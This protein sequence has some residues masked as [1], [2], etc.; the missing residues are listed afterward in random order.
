MRIA[1]LDLG[2]NTFLCLIADVDAGEIKRVISD[3]ARV[4]RLG[5]DV[6]QS[7]RFHPEALARAEA[8]LADY[9]SEIRKQSVDRIVAAATSAARDVA[10]GEELLAI[11]RKHGIPIEIIS[12]VREAEST[13]LGTVS[14]RPS[15]PAAIIDVGGGSTEFIFGDA[16][17]I[18]EKISVDVG[19]VR[20][21]ELFVTGHPIA[22]RELDAMAGHIREKLQPVA[23][24]LRGLGL[25][26]GI[27]VAGTPTTLAAI[28]MGKPFDAELVHGYRFRIE[29]LHAW[30]NRLAAMT[31]AERQALNGL[32]AKRADVIPAGSLVLALGCEAL[33]LSEIEVSIRGLRYGLALLAEREETSCE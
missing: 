26:Q 27:A 9:A 6:H 13:F 14:G 16:A 23:R 30:T 5:Q 2:T 20:M 29:K 33:G 22:A 28:D 18:K 4:V 12:G 19:S 3:Q 15:A 1:A 21:T 11:G 24:K 8:C 25:R 7:R 17:G 10:N 31:I 32:D